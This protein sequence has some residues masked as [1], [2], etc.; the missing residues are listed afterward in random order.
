MVA[1]SCVSIVMARIGL[2][3]FRFDGELLRMVVAY[4]YFSRV[5]RVR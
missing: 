2:F 1:E 5:C 3:I 4:N